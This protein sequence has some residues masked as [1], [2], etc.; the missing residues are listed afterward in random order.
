MGSRG[1]IGGEGIG[2]RF[3]QNTLNVHMEFS[4]NKNRALKKKE[5]S[6]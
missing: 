4:S 6:I 5:L 1:E 2:D 3:D